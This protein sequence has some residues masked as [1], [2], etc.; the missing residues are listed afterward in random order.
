MESVNR[1]GVVMLELLMTG[2][3]YP[4]GQLVE[5]ICGMEASRRIVV[6][7]RL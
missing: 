2:T 1:R 5:E 3:E 4:Q 7:R 6:R